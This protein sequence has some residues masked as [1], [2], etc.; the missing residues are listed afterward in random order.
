MT[1]SIRP[2]HPLFVG[3]VS[4]IDLGQPLSPADVAAIEAGMD[5]HAVLIFH[6]QTLTN[7][8][9]LAFSRNFGEL[10]EGANTSTKR[11]N[12]RLDPIFAD[13][14]NLGQD[15]RPRDRLHPAR[16]DKMGNRLWH[17]D[18]SFKVRGAKYSILYG[19]VIPPTGGD[20]EFADMRAAYDAL[21][22]ATKAEVEDLIC[23]HSISFSRA[24]LGFMHNDDDLKRLPPVRQRLVRVHPVTGRRSLYLAS[25]IGGI[26]G[27]PRPEAMA[28]IRDL[29]EHATQ[30]PFVYTHRWTAGD[31]LMWDNRQTMHRGRRYDDVTYPRDVRRTTLLGDGPTAEQVRMAG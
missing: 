11:E 17:T 18:A 12:L 5:R 24:Q 26:V 23:E 3:E 25:H 2:L 14:S 21:D 10:Q 27:W 16:Q 20:T 30:R 31:V 7:E 1:V 13:P 28:F 29:I 4:G 9:Q 15:G 19:R 22:A 6:G 8:Q